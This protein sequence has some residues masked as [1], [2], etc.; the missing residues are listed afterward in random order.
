MLRRIN[1]LLNI[2][3]GS[4]VGV[5]IGRGI[6]E[7]CYFKKHPDL[8]AMQAIPWYF[9]VLIYG[10]IAL[11]TVVVCFVLKVVVQKISAG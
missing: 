11:I 8:Y 2:V 1:Q 3:I 7:Y 10:V 6:Y 9:G 5:F 4:S